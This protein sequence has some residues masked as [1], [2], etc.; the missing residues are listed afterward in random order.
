MTEIEI[1]T[2]VAD[3][4]S[5]LVVAV[6]V[7]FLGIDRGNDNSALTVSI[8]CSRLLYNVNAVFKL[9]LYLSSHI[10][11][12][13]DKAENSRSFNVKAYRNYAV[14][15]KVCVKRVVILAVVGN[16]NKL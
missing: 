6:L 8:R 10:V 1:V 13:K 5:K 16:D 4:V 11:H 9:Y 7:S 2:V 15:G 3:S 14:P 12:G